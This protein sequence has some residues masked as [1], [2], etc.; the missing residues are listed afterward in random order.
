MEA[1]LDYSEVLPEGMKSIYAM[2]HYSS[3]CGLEPGLLD[4]IKF[5]RHRSTA[6]AIALTCTQRTPAPAAR[7]SSVFTV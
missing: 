6:A 3:H 1:R 2:D 7:R 5:V 4:L